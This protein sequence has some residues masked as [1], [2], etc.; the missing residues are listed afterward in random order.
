MHGISICLLG[1]ATN[2]DNLCI[3]MA[4]GCRGQKI[5]LRMNACIALIS[6]LISLVLCLFSSCIAEGLQTLANF[7]GACLLIAIGIWTLW[8]KQQKETAV[9]AQAS[10]WVLG[11]ALAVNC[12][13]AAFGA[14]LTGLSPIW[15]GSTVAVFSFVTV[16]LGNRLGCSARERWPGRLLDVVSALCMLVIG[17][18]EMLW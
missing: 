10:A 9:A 18:V 11:L 6:G 17:V 3:G 4:Y 13:P 1:I 7:I 5:A 14:G 8:P 12:I 2:L 16:G 15:L